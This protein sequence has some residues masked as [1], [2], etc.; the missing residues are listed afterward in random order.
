MHALTPRALCA[1][2]VALATA[3]GAPSEAPA[4]AAAPETAEPRDG[5]L[6]L[7]PEQLQTARIG[8]G[9]AER[10]A[11]TAALVA[12]GEVEPPA[13]G[14]AQVSPRVAGRVARLTK[15]VG[16][17]VK[18][19][20]V[21][22][23]IDS[24]ELGRAKADF[25]AAAASATVAREGAD[26]ERSLFDQ[27]I[28][29]E[30]ELRLAEAEATRARADKEAAE[31]RLH[32]LGVSDDQLG[33]LR[34]DDHF[35]GSVAIT[36]PM[37]GVVVSRS[38]SLGQHAE[39]QDPMF[40]I[41]DLRTVWI[42]VDVYERDLAQVVLGQSVVVRVPAW[43]ART[44]TG[45]VAVIGAVVDHR[46]RTIKLRVVLPNA[47]GALKPGMFATV[48]IAGTTGAP[49]EGVYVAASAVQRDGQRSLVFVRR[50]PR[51]FEPRVVE[52]GQVARDWIEITRGVTAGEELAT[53]GTFALKSELE[54]GDLGEDE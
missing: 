15:G 30:K 14:V 40:E 27:R 10:R 5:L 6:H 48:E 45:T 43:P 51:D 46:S 32:T 39:P 19:G 31:V 53:A 26:R 8:F 42:S 38:V 13:D 49:R 24:P 20:E 29:S 18:R 25:I 2:L 54:K 16:D 21:V 34:A 28:S 44:F 12:T 35:S 4:P 7:T 47:D 23:V 33:A 22:A 50:G 11:E 1:I 52:V 9:R 37:T 17:Q 41:M 3:C 36:A